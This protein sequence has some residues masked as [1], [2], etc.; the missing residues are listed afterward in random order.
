MDRMFRRIAVWFLL[1]VVL[2]AGSGMDWDSARTIRP[3]I[4]LLQF[5]KKE[6]RLLKY[7]IMRIDLQTPGLSFVT[8]GRDPDWGKPMPDYPK[9]QIRT[10]RITT[11]EFMQNHRKPQKEGGPGLNMV[12]AFNGSGWG[13]WTPPFTHKYGDPPGITISDGVVVSDRK[14]HKPMFVVYRDG[15]CDIVDKL[16]KRD[17][18]KVRNSIPCLDAIVVRDSKI[19]GGFGKRDG[20]APRTAYGLSRD[21]RYFFVLVVDGRQPGWSLGA[22]HEDLARIMLEAGA[23]IAMNMD[24]GGSSSMLMWDRRKKKPVMIN[25]HDPNRAYMRPVASNLGIVI[26]KNAR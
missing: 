23:D 20:L 3:G 2:F 24:G 21:R 6:P 19:V 12:V 7:Y 17:Y 22:N 16:E 18:P 8:T 15:R 26:E 10:K 5:R 9:R 1:A 14:P 13:P 11:A 25:R 4:R